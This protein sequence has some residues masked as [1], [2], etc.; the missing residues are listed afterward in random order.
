MKRDLE[1]NG[2]PTI[3]FDLW[4]SGGDLSGRSGANLARFT[5][6]TEEEAKRAFDVVWKWEFRVPLYIDPR[7]RRWANVKWYDQPH[8]R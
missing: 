6:R 1:A 8:W 2:W 4:L 3:G 7:G 5:I